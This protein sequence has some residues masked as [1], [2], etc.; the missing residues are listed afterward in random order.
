MAD[1]RNERGTKTASRR[2]ESL[3]DLLRLSLEDSEEMVRLLRRIDTGITAL[4]AALRPSGG[5]YEAALGG[6]PK[7]TAEERASLERQFG[8]AFDA[9]T[10]ADAASLAERLPSEHR[11]TF[12][13]ADKIA[14][15][16]HLMRLMAM[17]QVE[18]PR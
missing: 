5:A 11:A 7:D 12:K 1:R 17:D 15:K 13:R 6:P 9:L 16:Y 14:V 18:R 4:L 8:K 3:E 2:A 10:E